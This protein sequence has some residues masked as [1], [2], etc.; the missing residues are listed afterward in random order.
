MKDSEI[1]IKN[2]TSNDADFLYLIMNDDRILNRLNEIPTTV[3]DWKEAVEVWSGDPDEENYLVWVHDCR[4][5]RFSLNNLESNDRVAYLKMAVLLPE[6]QHRGVGSIVLQRLL[7]D[8][9][10]RGYSTVMLYTNADNVN[11]QKCYQKCG[12]AVVEEFRDVMA[13]GS[14]VGRYKMR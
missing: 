9:K 5:G 13:D 10:D 3:D 7:E 11:A 4:A 6:Y 1:E 8:L 14:C 2:V 12:F